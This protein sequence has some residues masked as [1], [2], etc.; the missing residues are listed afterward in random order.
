[1]VIPT[2]NEA[3]T[4]DEVLRRVRAALPD[5]EVLVV[6]DDS[7]DG[8]ADLV[9]RAGRELGG[10]HVLRRGGRPGFGAAYR[11]GFAWGMDRGARVLVQMDA[12]LSHDP[13][14]LPTLVGALD[15][16]D[17]VVGSRYVPGG[18]V[19]RWGL[20]RRLL[21]RGG[22]IY[23]A[24]ALGVAVRDMTSGYRVHRA[25]TLR[26]IDLETVR[27]DGYGF[28]IEVL[29]R[30]AQKGARIREV[31]ICFVDRE[32]GRSKMSGRIVAEALGLV[33]WW[34]A[35]RVWAAARD[36]VPARG[37]SAVATNRRSTARRADPPLAGDPRRTPPADP[38]P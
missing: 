30:A 36:R 37:P 11:A 8:T 5:A 10:V 27:A 24:L 29:Y 35:A 3:E 28:Q 9:E 38:A 6:D 14:A 34:G 18:S 17:M 15:G 19:P 1:M 25:E 4:I 26:S 16:C 12:D 32:L 22:N 33:T 2:F 20:H 23:S 31:P 13:T 7:P 21:S